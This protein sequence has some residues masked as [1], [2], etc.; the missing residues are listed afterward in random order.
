MTTLASGNIEVAR[1]GPYTEADSDWRQVGNIQ[2]DKYD[3][4]FRY[5][6][7]HLLVVSLGTAT[8]KWYKMIDAS[9]RGSIK[10]QSVAQRQLEKEALGEVRRLVRLSD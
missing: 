4:W 6:N 1:R 8:K 10:S 9:P 5:L 2:G 7:G 3:T